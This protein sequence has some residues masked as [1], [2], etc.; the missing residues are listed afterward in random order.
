MV[1]IVE[2]DV[3]K[4]LGIGG[5][6]GEF[7][8]ARLAVTFR[9]IGV[10]PRAERVQTGRKAQVGLTYKICLILIRRYASP[11]SSG[12]PSN[13]RCRSPSRRPEGQELIRRLVMFG[14]TPSSTGTGESI[15]IDREDDD[16]AGGHI[17]PK[18]RDVHERQSVLQTAERQRAN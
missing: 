10:W 5:A 13:R 16:H 2:V 9:P 12:P 18:R 3:R 8:R 15:S 6:L 7:E 1:R 11:I 17:L 14:P 4:A